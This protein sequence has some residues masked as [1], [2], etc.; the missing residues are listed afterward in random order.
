MLVE[1]DVDVTD[2]EVIVEAAG[3]TT[4]SLTALERSEFVRLGIADAALAREVF[5]T[6][7]VP[8]GSSGSEREH[9]AIKLR[10]YV[11]VCGL[12]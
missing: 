6:S 2:D 1:V 12:I 8:P 11:R 9:N 4:W 5:R 10:A 3:V 7:L